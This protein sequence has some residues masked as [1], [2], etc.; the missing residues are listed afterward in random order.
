[1]VKILGY[2]SALSSILPLLGGIYN[3]KQLG[4]GRRVFLILVVYMV[5]ADLLM[6]YMSRNKMNNLGVMN[7]NI[8]IEVLFIFKLYDVWL[9]NKYSKWLLYSGI[10]Y[11]LFWLISIYVYSAEIKI[12]LLAIGMG[13]IVIAISSFY[14]LFH[15][16]KT[17]TTSFV[18]NP[19]FIISSGV[20]IYFL[21][22][23]LIFAVFEYLRVTNLVDPAN[24]YTFHSILN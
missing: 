19:R 11:T 2:I 24:Y 8:L 3:Y 4:K 16:S 9:E 23:T 20:F 6:I 1:M 17:T 22:T 13:N 12:N 21:S 7:M 18:N 14:Y 10:L 15:L 5:L